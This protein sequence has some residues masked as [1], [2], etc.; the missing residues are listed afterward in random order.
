M[1]LAAMVLA[2]SFGL[3]S[4]LKAALAAALL[5]FPSRW[6]SPTTWASVSSPMFS[7]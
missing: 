6:R 5:M 4:V 1:L 2:V 7:P 3:L